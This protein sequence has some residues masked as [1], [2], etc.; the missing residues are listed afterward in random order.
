MCTEISHL[1]VRYENKWS[2]TSAPTI[3]HGVARNNF[4]LS[5]IVFSI[6]NTISDLFYH[7]NY[8]QFHT[9]HEKS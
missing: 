9:A 4:T 3:L 6:T 8:F 1:I 5:F 2:S 7:L